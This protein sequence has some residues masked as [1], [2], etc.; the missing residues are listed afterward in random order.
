VWKLEREGVGTFKKVGMYLA[1]PEVDVPGQVPPS[2]PMKDSEVAEYIGRWTGV[3]NGVL[4]AS[5]LARAKKA[6]TKE[7]ARMLAGI[8]SGSPEVAAWVVE[9]LTRV[10]IETPA[11]TLQ[12]TDALLREMIADTTDAAAPADGGS[13]S[14]ENRPAKAAK[15]QGSQDRES[16]VWVPA[17]VFA[18]VGTFKL[19]QMGANG[20]GALQ[21]LCATLRKE[22]E[23]MHQPV[24]G[25]G[26]GGLTEE[27]LV[28]VAGL[29][30]LSEDKRF[31]RQYLA[32]RSDIAGGGA[33]NAE[34]GQGQHVLTLLRE[35]YYSHVRI[36]DEHVEAGESGP[37]IDDRYAI[38][39]VS[40]TA[41]CP[42][43]P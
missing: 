17:G 30:A 32:A 9:L 27:D 16:A 25:E 22:L 21:R 1:L 4:C 39:G 24:G 34:G 19:P 33:S 14:G 20:H 11:A 6:A 43:H 38:D 31:L 28:R 18:G 23:E 3:M 10:L 13:S 7:G 29:L 2:R 8:D 5:D 41:F 35:L 37:R 36:L 15:T 42:R 12:E 40:L 26:P